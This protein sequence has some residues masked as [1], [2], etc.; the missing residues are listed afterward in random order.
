MN[1]SL[2]ITNGDFTTNR[3]Q[4]LNINGEI[5]TWREMLC[6]GKTLMEVG[7]ESFWKTRF[8]FLNT[9]YKVSKKK[10]IDFTVK[11]YR[12]L[13]QQ[14]SQDEITLWFD[15]DLFSQINMLAVIS[16]LKRY[17]KGRKLTLIQGIVTKNKNTKNIAN[18]TANQLTN[19][20]QKRVELTKDDIEYADY[21]WQLYCS[22]CPLRLETAHQLN[23]SPIF[24]NLETAIK[25]HI[26]RF[27]SIETGLNVIEKSIV[28]T[29]NS[30]EKPIK[31]KVEFIKILLKNQ[32]F[33]GYNEL[34]Y[35]AKIDDLKKLF[36]S[37]SPVKL[38]R[39]GKK[40]LDN[41]LNYYRKIRNENAYLGGAKKYSFL[42]MNSTN[43]LLKITS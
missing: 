33:Y 22:G 32:E 13:C 12:N 29:V 6:E 41:Q 18:L 42:Y 40:V 19:L 15:N 8:E 3:L 30:L 43:K 9:S 10:F 37:F 16:W 17:R 4:N 5:I 24:S 14:K 35:T 25:T 28:N 38:S 39:T 20:H 23:N 27:P 34:Q 1:V 11:E 2:H 21:I 26:L 36:S 7:S 31:S